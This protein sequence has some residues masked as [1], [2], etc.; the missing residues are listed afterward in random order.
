[1]YR[2]SVNEQET[3]SIADTYA[4]AI[5]RTL[6]SLKPPAS[7]T[8]LLHSHHRPHSHTKTVSQSVV[9]EVSGFKICPHRTVELSVLSSFSHSYFQVELNG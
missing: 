2:L 6:S 7:P 4:H 5:L 3:N 9:N 1:M 8:I